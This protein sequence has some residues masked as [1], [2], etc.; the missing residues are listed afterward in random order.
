MLILFSVSPLGTFEESGSTTKIPSWT[1]PRMP[2][3]ALC[4][5][6]QKALANVS[7]KRTVRLK[8]VKL[9]RHYQ[10]GQ[11]WTNAATMISWFHLRHRQRPAWR[12]NNR[13]R[14]SVVSAATSDRDRVGRFGGWYFRQ[15]KNHPIRWGDEQRARSHR[16]PYSLPRTHSHRRQSALRYPPALQNLLA[17][18]LMLFQPHLF[19]SPE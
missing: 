15:K 18:K 19:S 5:K 7:E 11:E 2:S 1:T 17:K 6:N 16:S 10:R 13:T 4:S 8:L 12:W 3:E 14:S 9:M